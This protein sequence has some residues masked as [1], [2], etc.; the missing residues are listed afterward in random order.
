[1]ASWPFT[2]TVDTYLVHVADLFLQQPGSPAP[3][4]GS[5]IAASY[6]KWVEVSILGCA[7]NTPNLACLACSHQWQA[8]IQCIAVAELVS[9]LRRLLELVL[10]QSCLT[11]QNRS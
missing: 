11:A 4:G 7:L 8:C 5:Y 10:S 9:P 2:C 6:V 3:K 1:M